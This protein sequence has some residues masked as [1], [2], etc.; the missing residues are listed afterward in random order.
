M[1]KLAVVRVR[2]GVKASRDVRETLR[3]LGLT[4]V[5][6]CIVLDDDPAYKGMLQKAK[7][8]ITWGE[9][10]PEVLEALLRKRG[11]L[12]GD[13]RLTDEYI[14]SY[15]SFSSIGEFAK[16]V[17]AGRAKLSAA[18]GLKKIFRLHPPRKGYRATKRPFRDG[19]SLG[20]RGEKINDLILRMI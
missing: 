1:V 18:P 4:R 15:T 19:G 8:M 12:T 16:A 7:D 5:N 3:M 9:I 14:K 11:R 20:N 17:H 13:K 10:R 2:G 6:H